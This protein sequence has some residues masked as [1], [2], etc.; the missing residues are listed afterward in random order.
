M[1]NIVGLDLSLTATGY[2]DADGSRVVKCTKYKGAERLAHF[3]TY[4]GRE[5]LDESPDLVVVEG[6]SFGSHDAGARSIGELGGVMR[7]LLWDMKIPWAEVPPT[8]LKKFAT[9][10]GNCSKDQVLAAAVRDDTRIDDNNAADA[11]WLRQMGFVAQEV[12]DGELEHTL[13]PK[14]RLEAIEGVVWP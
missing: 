4:F 14:Y 7:L 13:I 5:W 3:R 1:T 12:M 11:H 9:G 2:S 6:Y 10:K 8:S